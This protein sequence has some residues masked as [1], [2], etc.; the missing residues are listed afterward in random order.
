MTDLKYEG[1]ERYQSPKVAGS[2][3]RRRFF[4]FKGRLTDWRE[5]NL[6]L[7]AL[8]KAKMERG[9]AL[10][11]PCGTGRMSE[12]L[13]EKG[14]QVVGADISEEMMSH[15]IRKTEKYGDRV[16]FVKADIENLHF[17][18]NSFD[19]ILTIRLLHHIPPEL[20]MRVL[21]E[22]HRV[23]K[24]W[25]IITFSNRYSLKNVWRNLLAAVSKYPRFAISPALFR[26][27]VDQA[28]FDIIDYSPMLPL[29]SE[30]V[31]VLLRKR[32]KN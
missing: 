31:T 15:A 28:G 13:L 11:L 32:S 12:M 19:V 7:N 9:S 17:P 24:E 1:K 29:F 21:Q 25:V 6:I 22:L 30:S 5:K 2:Y 23:T 16:K 8:Q 10:D 20:H 26:S 27:E 4:S 18:D 3:D 14:W